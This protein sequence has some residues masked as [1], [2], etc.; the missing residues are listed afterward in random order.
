MNYEELVHDYVDGNLDPK[1]EEQLFLEMA[2]NK[3]LRTEL[4]RN[5]EFERSARFDTEAYTPSAAATASIFSQLNIDSPAPVSSGAA[6]SPPKGG[7]FGFLQK[8]STVLFSSAASAVVAALITFFSIDSGSGDVNQM[9]AAHSGE[10]NFMAAGTDTTEQVEKSQNIPMVKSEETT[11]TQ[12]PKSEETEKVK[13]KIVYV[14]VPAADYY[15]MMQE[16]AKDNDAAKEIT[17][18]KD[19][20]KKKLLKDG[21]QGEL[22][23]NSPVNIHSSGKEMALTSIRSTDYKTI[24]LSMRNQLGLTVEVNNSD[25]WSLPTAAVKR[26][27]NPAFEDMGL[28]LLYNFSDKFAAG[29]DLRQEFFFHE[30][31]GYENDILYNYKQNTNFFSY[32]VVFRYKPFVLF[33][34]FPVILQ[35]YAGGNEAGPIARAMFGLGYSPYHNINFYLGAEGS[36]LRYYHND[37]SQQGTNYYWSGKFGVNYGVSVKF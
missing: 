2:S 17:E 30:Y 23:L 19:Q 7:F 1:Q 36:V 25:Y 15:A 12:Q 37:A 6:G 5:I 9:P 28:T 24:D 21:Y 34:E 31:T 13:E 20:P 16:K 4:K 8:N 3:K 18:K 10:S 14:P 22:A 35:G 32:G 29:L 27:S 26:S 33:E 11:E